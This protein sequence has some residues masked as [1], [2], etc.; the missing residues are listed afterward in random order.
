[1]TASTIPAATRR[2]GVLGWLGRDHGSPVPNATKPTDDDG[3]QAADRRIE[4]QRRLFREVGDLIFAHGLTPSP[5]TYAVIHG[6]LSG[7]DV[8]VSAAVTAELRGGDPLTDAAIARIADADAPAGMSPEALTRIADALEARIADCFNATGQSRESA[9]TFGT[10]LGKEAAHL[11][12]EPHAALERIIT[13][14][15]DAVAAT[16]LVEEQLQQTREEADA[17]RCDLQRARRAAEQDHLT[18]LPNRRSFEGKLHKAIDSERG[19]Q[20]IVALCDIDDF[21]QV[22]DRFGHAAGDRVLKFVATF[23][24]AQLPRRVVVARYGG[25]EFACLFKGTTME[26]AM[27]TLDQARERLSTRSLVIQG[28]GETLG[29]VTFSAGLTTVRDTDA[30]E[31]LRRADLALYAAKNAGKNRVHRADQT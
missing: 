7:E 22:N 19:D 27:A 26:E 23:L 10:A 30:D 20:T 25:E 31:A 1:M 18:S 12:H 2:R 3:A 29:H 14:T 13:L 15:R 4:V 21:K 11:E 9:A 28:S 17:L 8:R 16:R 6:Y 5:R 24:R